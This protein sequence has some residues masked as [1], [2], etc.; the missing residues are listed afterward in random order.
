MDA[1]C[2]R[3][4]LIRV[5]RKFFLHARIFFVAT[6]PSWQKQRTRID[7]VAV[8]ARR[9]LTS[10]LPASLIIASPLWDF[11]RHAARPGR[12]GTSLLNRLQPNLN[13]KLEMPLGKK[14][15]PVQYLRAIRLGLPR[16]RMRVGLGF[17]N[18]ASLRLRRGFVPM[19]FR[20]P[21]LRRADLSP[22]RRGRGLAC[23]FC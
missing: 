23:A 3:F 6:A 21:P 18:H 7:P 5:T 19:R 10:C 14:T 12:Q 4:R 9:L 13:V 11:R 8:I 2:R 1:R 17:V 16:A 20:G 22:T 15:T